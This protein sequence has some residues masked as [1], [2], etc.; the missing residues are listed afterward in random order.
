MELRSLDLE[1]QCSISICVW[2][3]GTCASQVGSWL[4]LQGARELLHASALRNLQTSLN[5]Q[6]GGLFLIIMTCGE[7]LQKTLPN[8]TCHGHLHLSLGM[9]WTIEVG[10]CVGFSCV[11][12]LES[13]FLASKRDQT[14]N[15]SNPV[16]WSSNGHYLYNPMRNWKIKASLPPKKNIMMMIQ[17]GISWKSSWI[18]IYLLTTLLCGMSIVFP[19]DMKLIVWGELWTIHYQ[20]SHKIN[21]RFEYD[22]H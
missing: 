14:L 16:L 20:S 4:L 11:L 6:I 10:G 2:T 21:K 15:V 3:L 22:R 13:K 7:R 19:I 18:S 12:L 1:P 17:I 8:G 5:L 9:V